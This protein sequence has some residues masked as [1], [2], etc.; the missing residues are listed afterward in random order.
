MVEAQAAGRPVVAA[1]AGGAR[2]I[3]VPGQTGV[4]VPDDADALAEALREI[5]FDSYDSADSAANAD[6]F[7]LESFKRK[8]RAE[9]QTLARMPISAPD[10]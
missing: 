2:E 3:V 9:V 4:L 6:R 8:L 5:D 10:G 7:S 1:E